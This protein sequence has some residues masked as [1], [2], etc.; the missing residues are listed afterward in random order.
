MLLSGGALL[1]TKLHFIRVAS[2]IAFRVIIFLGEL[3]ASEQINVKSKSMRHARSQI[4]Y[5]YEFGTRR[6]WQHQFIEH[7]WYILPIYTQVYTDGRLII[8]TR[9]IFGLVIW[10]QGGAV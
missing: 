4:W 1:Y 9:S 3:A 2:V 6:Q 10:N 7:T 8:A 5:A